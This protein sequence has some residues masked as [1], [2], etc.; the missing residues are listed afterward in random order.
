MPVIPVSGPVAGSRIADFDIQSY[1]FFG[2]IKNNGTI[3]AKA[4]K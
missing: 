2:M 3:L 4:V 1:I